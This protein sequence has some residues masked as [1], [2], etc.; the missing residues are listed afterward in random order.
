M[1]GSAGGTSA[2]CF[3]PSAF[4]FLRIFTRST[5]CLQPMLARRGD[6]ALRVDRLGVFAERVEQRRRGEGVD[7]PR[8]PAARG[9]DLLH[10]RAAE[11]VPRAA[12]DAD[13][14]L[15]VLDRLFERQRSEAVAHAA[16]APSPRPRTGAAPA[17]RGA[18]G[19][20]RETRDRASCRRAW[21][22]SRR[23]IRT[24]RDCN[25]YAGLGA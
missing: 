6:D 16:P 1:T 22:R 5:M 24:Y 10:G 23:R 8:D 13:A 2:F 4:A 11:R 15:D 20:R 14:M 17:P 21:S 12:A 18:A 7:Q 9:V 19:S 25:G 3:L